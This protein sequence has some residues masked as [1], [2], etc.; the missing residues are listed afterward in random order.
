MMCRTFTRTRRSS[1]SSG[2]PGVRSVSGA[3]PGS[4]APGLAPGASRFTTWRSPMPG[5][6]RPRALPPPSMRSK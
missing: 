2:S 3:I 4:P 5:W 1:S 6:G